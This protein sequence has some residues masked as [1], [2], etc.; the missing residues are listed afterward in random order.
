MAVCSN[1]R[2]MIPLQTR[3]T[4]LLALPALLWGMAVGEKKAPESLV[5]AARLS[6]AIQ[7]CRNLGAM[8]DGKQHAPPI[9]CPG[10]FRTL[11]PVVLFWDSAHLS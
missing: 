4:V 8:C 10:T 2:E 11:L 6:Q 1:V 5:L 9:V 3:Q 7:F